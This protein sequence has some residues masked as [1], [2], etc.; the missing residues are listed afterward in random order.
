MNAVYTTQQVYFIIK[1]LLI[2]DCDGDDNRKVLS[3]ICSVLL[4]FVG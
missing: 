1:P 2:S 4:K 3:F